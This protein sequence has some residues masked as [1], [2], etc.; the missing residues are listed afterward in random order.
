MS[1]KI[2]EEAG[3]LSIEL[4]RST[5]DRERI[6]AEAAD[7]LFHTLIG[8]AVHGVTLEEVERELARRAGTSGLDEK[9]G[10]PTPSK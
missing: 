8:L 2:V 6:V 4:A 5:P 9:A 1:E 7:L 10:R 3:E